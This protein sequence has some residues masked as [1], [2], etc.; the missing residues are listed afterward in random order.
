MIR[1]PVRPAELRKRID[2]DSPRFLEEAEKR[3]AVFKRLKRYEEKASAWGDIKG[4]YMALQYNKCAYCERRLAGP[5]YGKVE[6]DI[7]HFRPKR[8]VR[9]WPTRKI[10]LARG[11]NYG[12]RT[13]N[14]WREGYYLLA[15][16]LENYATACK[17]CNSALKGSAFPIAGKRGPQRESP[18]Q[19]KSEKPFLIYP[20]GS[21]DSD[22]EQLITFEGI[23]PKPVARPGTHAFKRATVTIDFFELDTRE[24]LLR[25]RT[26]QIR[27]LWLTLGALETERDPK[28]RRELEHGVELLESLHSPHTNCVRSF[29]RLYKA[30]PARAR[31]LYEELKRYLEPQI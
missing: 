18:R 24:E 27:A 22:P 20:I 17:T 1:Y 8:N 11:I 16:H 4:V 28:K 19:L 14:V 23:L 31:E 25:E 9:A 12:F 5:R 7:E 6:H 21:L 3:T 29:H 13:G 2:A 15:Y 30:N 10:A 26:E